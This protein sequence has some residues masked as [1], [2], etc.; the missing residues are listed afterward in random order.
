MYRG[1]EWAFIEEH[2]HDVLGKQSREAGDLEAA[3]GH[4][5]A[6]LPCRHSPESWQQF[7]LRQFLEAVQQAA[8]ERVRPELACSQGPGTVYCCRV[9]QRLSFAVHMCTSPLH[10]ICWS[11]SFKLDLL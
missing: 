3:I 5:A 1:R 8:G 2:L 11:S 4:F 7:Y 6:M 10:Q 9:C